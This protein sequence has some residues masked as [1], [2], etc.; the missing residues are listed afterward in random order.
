MKT[1]CV[2]TEYKF[3]V[4]I[5]NQQDHTV[6]INKGVL[7]YA[8]TDIQGEEKVDTSQDCDEFTATI[9]NGS[10]EFD[11]CVMLNTLVNTTQERT[12]RV[13]DSCI[14][15]INFQQQSI[16]ESN[17]S[18]V[19]C[20]SA[21]KSMTQGFAEMVCRRYTKMRNFCSSNNSNVNEIIVYRNSISGQIS[22][23]L[24]TKE[25]YFQKPTYQKHSLCTR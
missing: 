12:S 23:N 7:G 4:L 13:Y 5:E 14:K 25:R 18:I 16:F 22:Y 20:I 15:C 10:S 24:I 9:L 21:D 2:Q 6:T 1:I 19:Q 17:M 11:S 3:P 8:V